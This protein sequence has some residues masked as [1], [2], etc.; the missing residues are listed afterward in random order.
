MKWIELN[1]K[2]RKKNEIIY[3]VAANKEKRIKKQHFF[4]SYWISLNRWVTKLPVLTNNYNLR[5]KIIYVN[6]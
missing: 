6:M 2:Y 5:L 1:Q 3:F 4:P